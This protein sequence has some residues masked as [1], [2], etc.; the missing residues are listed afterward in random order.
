MIK[1]IF[2]FLIFVSSLFS[3]QIGDCV[4]YGDGSKGLIIGSTISVH[5]T[6]FNSATNEATNV[7]TLHTPN[8]DFWIFKG[9]TFDSSSGTW[10]YSTF[11]IYNNGGPCTPTAPMPLC[12]DNQLYD[13]NTS[14]CVS[15]P[16]P[17]TFPSD[18][19]ASHGAI[20][21]G[22]APIPKAS[23]NSK[24]APDYSTTLGTYHIVGWD[25][26]RKKCLALAFKCNSGFVYDK[27]RKTCTQPPK[28][29]TIEQNNK[30]PNDSANK[31][32]GSKWG[33]TWTYNFCEQCKGNVG[34]WLPPVGLE[35]Y[36]LQCNKKYI[37]YQCT[38][39]YR[40]KKF[41]QVSC[42]NILPKDKTTK[43]I[44]LSKLN[45][46]PTKDT[47]ISSLPA[48]NNTR[49][50]TT[51]LSKQIEQN[52][53]LNSKVS[54]AE[55]QKKLLDGINK[56][57]KKLDSLNKGHL[58]QDGV[59]NGVKRAL[60]ARDNN[61]SIPKDANKTGPGGRGLKDARNAIIKQYGIKYD[62]FGI[63]T[64][65]APSFSSSITFMNMQVQNPMPVMDNALKAYY[66]MFKSL[67]LVVATFLGL[68]SVFRR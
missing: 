18:A 52:K 55:N 54:T 3:N 22:Y 68:L 14:T 44:D 36:G 37:E 32:S 47:N 26:S 12:A 43:K 10:Y 4:P 67:F 66:P 35:G 11:D 61:L 7:F 39:D 64:C 40:L 58:S 19:N 13:V 23:C 34:I 63:S 15:P 28:T 27:N 29:K 57:G 5:R 9:K 33:Q 38:T 41:E 2:L 31:C 16:V 17:N 42:G 65:G 46:T 60:D 20:S 45:T 8:Y 49:S 48:K 30:N 51:M 62:L 24:S 50:I 53:A 59:K 6:N 25:L 56:L 1:I 21:N